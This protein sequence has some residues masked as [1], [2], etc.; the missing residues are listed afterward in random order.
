MHP[1]DI[2]LAIA[3][4][5]TA[6]LSAEDRYRRLLAAISRA[7]PCDAASLMRL[8][9]NTLVP[10]AIRGLVPDTMGRRFPLAEHPRLDIIANAT[11]PVLFPPDSDLP[12][13]FD[14][15]VATDATALGRVHACLGCPLDIEG[16]RI[17]VLTADALRPQAFDDLDLQWVGVLGAMAG[18]AMHTTG[19]IDALEEA[20]ARQGL[21]AQELMRDARDR[22][23]GELIGV[24]PA[25]NHLREEISLIAPSTFTVLIT[26]ETGAGKE[27]VAHAI[28][29]ASPRRDRPLT[30]V[31]CAALPTSLVESE[32]FGH[33]RGAFTG[34]AS[35][36]HGKFDV[37]DG[38]TLLLDEIGELPIELQPK[39]L[40]VL[41][42][43]EIQR[44]GQDKTTRVN[45]RLLAATNRDLQREVREGR[46]RA[47]LY[48]R[49]H[50][51]PLRVPA[52]RERVEDIPIFAGHFLERI[53][54]RLGIQ[55]VRLTSDALD[56]LQAYSWPGNVRELENVLS[57]AVLQ[58]GASAPR[59]APVL[60]SSGA[61]HLGRANAVEP[62]VPTDHIASA[63][64]KSL[65]AAVDDFRRAAIM[66]AVR[67]CNGNW[68]AAARMLG[69]HRSNLHH[70]ARRLG[71]GPDS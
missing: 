51:Y 16:R 23:G 43:G 33:V 27:V 54:R 25:I 67:T 17:G 45:V 30:H 20:A 19:L 65:H 71:I 2:L 63:T 26:G 66:N 18:A 55:A 58:A 53:R 48:H 69:M 64:Q 70:L 9:S 8:D 60:V 41:Q 1:S 56:A 13:P 40:R 21:I 32:L 50:V 12:D 7:I 37:A 57:R 3:V 44:V 24:S 31:N 34:A 61:L 14:G 36:R 46:F 10:V 42:S 47:D 29:A 62:P 6:A 39:L 68:A 35:D 52:L 4:D 15:L 49:L 38:G 5:L 11:D 59:G 28:H 22:Q